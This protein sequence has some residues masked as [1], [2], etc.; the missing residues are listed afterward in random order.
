MTDVSATCPGVEVSGDTVIIG[1]YHD[2]IH[3]S[4]YDLD[5]FVEAV[6]AARDKVRRAGH[7]TAWAQDADG[8]GNC[9]PVPSTEEPK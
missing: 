1:D 5:A 3:I 7:M 8:Q 6:V 4:A 2:R 9:G